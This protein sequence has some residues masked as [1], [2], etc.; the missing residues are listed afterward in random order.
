MAL[1]DYIPLEGNDIIGVWRNS[2]SLEDLLLD[3]K[4]DGVMLHKLNELKNPKRQKEFCSTHLLLREL[5]GERLLIEK[6]EFGKPYLK[7]FPFHIS[8]THTNQFCA[9]ILSEHQPCGIDIESADRRLCKI[10]HKFVSSYEQLYVTKGYED[11]YYLII[12]TVKEAIYKWYGKKGLDFI[13]NMIIHPFTIDKEHG[14]VYYEF[15]FQGKKITSIAYYSVLH[16]HI[17][18]WLQG[19]SI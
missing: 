17:I 1:V 8:I 2:E 9:V 16:N 7:N 6:D 19:D 10:K 4:P 5:A 15:V 11:A 14:V 18:T 13:Q 12:W 3:L